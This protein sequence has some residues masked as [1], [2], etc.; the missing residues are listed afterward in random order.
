MSA[1]MMALFDD[2]GSTFAIPPLTQCYD[3]TALVTGCKIWHTS[4]TVAGGAGIVTVYPTLNG[5]ATG[6]PIFTNIMF[7]AATTT[8]TGTVATSAFGSL[9]SISGTLQTVTFIMMCGQGVILGGNSTGP[10][11]NGRPVDVL[12]FGN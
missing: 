7:G 12:L 4:A 11:A 6:T 10:L 3:G 9:R 2:N 5:T 1:Q 8:S